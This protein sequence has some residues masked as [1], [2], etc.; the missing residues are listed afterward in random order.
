MIDQIMLKPYVC[1]CGLKVSHI[2]NQ[3]LTIDRKFEI[4]ELTLNNLTTVSNMAV[5]MVSEVMRLLLSSV[6]GKLSN[7]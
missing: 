7:S 2:F 1:L 3:I 5:N 4:D 6:E